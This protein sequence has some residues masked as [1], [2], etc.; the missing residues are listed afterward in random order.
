MSQDWGAVADAINTRMEELQLTQQELAGRAQVSVAL[1]RQ[2]QRNYAPRKRSPRTLEAISV[3]L[4]W[5]AGR[6]MEIS[7]GQT[8]TSP[9]DPVDALRAEFAD[10][11]AEVDDLRQRVEDLAATRQQG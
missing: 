4:K 7:N 10:L 11:R 5:P 6:L 9:D 3:A 1:L 8:E 2:L